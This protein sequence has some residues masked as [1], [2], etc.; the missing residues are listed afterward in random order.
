MATSAIQFL[1]DIAQTRPEA[2][3]Y[4]SWT[5]LTAQKALA[6]V[7]AAIYARASHRHAGLKFSSQNNNSILQTDKSQNSQTPDAASQLVDP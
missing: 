3:W 7:S 4:L 6:N 5:Q 2:A 1:S